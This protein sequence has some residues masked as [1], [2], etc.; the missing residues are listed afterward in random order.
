MYN[1]IK[2]AGKSDEP[3]PEKRSQSITLPLSLL[4]TL[5]TFHLKITLVGPLPKNAPSV[6]MY[7]CV[8]IEIFSCSSSQPGRERAAIYTSTGVLFSLHT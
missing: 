6:F 8:L 4:R 5:Y 3:W 7:V 1:E 2:V